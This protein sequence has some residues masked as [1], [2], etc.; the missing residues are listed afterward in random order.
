[1]TIDD[2]VDELMLAADHADDMAQY[3]KIMAQIEELLRSRNQN[4]TQ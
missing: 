2:Y 1:M 4:Q 3:L